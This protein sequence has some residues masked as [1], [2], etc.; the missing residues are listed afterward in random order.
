[1][2]T[3]NLIIVALWAG[4]ATAQSFADRISSI[5][6]LSNISFYV[7]QNPELR[8]VFDSRNVTILAPEDSAFHDLVGMLQVNATEPL[9]NA[10]GIRGILEYHIVNGTHPSTDFNSTP[11]FLSTHL[12][13]PGF[14]NVSGGQVVQIVD[15]DGTLECISGLNAQARFVRSVSGRAPLCL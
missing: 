6:E 12:T 9:P 4:G 7:G 10:T 1:M 15:R 8:S 11:R 13:N 14:T 5:P 3:S 2:K